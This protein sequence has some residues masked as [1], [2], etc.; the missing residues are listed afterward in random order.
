MTHCLLQT[1]GSNLT[2][3]KH[4]DHVLINSRLGEADNSREATGIVSLST[5]CIL[6]LRTVPFR[7]VLRY[8]HVYY[9]T[10]PA[11][12]IPIFYASRCFATYRKI[13]LHTT[14]SLFGHWYHPVLSAG[15]CFHDTII[16]VRFAVRTTHGHV[17]KWTSQG[18]LTLGLTADHTTGGI[19]SR[20]FVVI[21]RRQI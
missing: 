18:A 21:A 3:A 13:S 15:V 6:A 2:T 1:T 19:R 9:K 14:V 7:C 20:A 4:A 17:D 10:S 5:D 8:V 11:T 12:T 16:G